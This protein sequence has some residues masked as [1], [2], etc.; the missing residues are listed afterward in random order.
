MFE[1]DYRSS[2]IPGG[3]AV[4]LDLRDMLAGIVR[5]LPFDYTLTP[6][7]DFTEGS[8]IFYGV[9]F[10]QPMRVAGEITNTA[11]Y[12]RM[13][14]TLSV[15]FNAP[16]SRCLKDTSDSFS[17]TLEK[18]VVPADVT[19][20]MDEDTI[21]DYAV[22]E[23]GF[24]DMDEQLLDLLYMEFPSK[25]LCSEDCKGLCAGCGANLNVEQCRC[26]PEVDPRLAPLQAI[27][28]DLQQAENSNPDENE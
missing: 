26:Q 4:Q 19:Q 14:L 20:D 7:T 8:S 11:G 28:D 13:T 9:T 16:C 12:M 15:E 6:P 17:L 23:D 18:T 22:I 2:K 3:F 21:D 25:I 10:T 24:L 27:L 5:M 1:Y